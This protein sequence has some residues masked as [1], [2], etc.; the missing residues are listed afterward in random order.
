MTEF[1]A[2]SQ[3][4]WIGY[5]YLQECAYI[6]CSLLS[7]LLVHVD[8][9]FGKLYGHF[10][11]RSLILRREV[12]VPPARGRP[13]KCRCFDIRNLR[14]H[15]NL[16]NSLSNNVKLFSS[17]GDL[18]PPHYSQTLHKL[19]VALSQLINKMPRGQ[20]S[21]KILIAIKTFLFH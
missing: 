15:L 11:N 5:L 10:G 2:A 17:P 4:P 18:V 6:F 19:N 16:W 1:D 3:A 7:I 13:N 21:F 12:T 14:R 8:V 20:T 9:L